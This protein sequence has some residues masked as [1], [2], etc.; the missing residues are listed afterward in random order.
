MVIQ[1]LDALPSTQRLMLPFRHK[2]AWK[3]APPCRKWDQ[4]ASG[5]LVLFFFLPLLHF[6]A[7]SHTQRFYKLQCHGPEGKTAENRMCIHPWRLTNAPGEIRAAAQAAPTCLLD[8]TRFP[9]NRNL[10]EFK[11]KESN[12]C[13]VNN[14]PILSQSLHVMGLRKKLCLL[15][16]GEIKLHWAEMNANKTKTLNKKKVNR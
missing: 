3:K 11:T 4:P 2:C 16:C 12:Y 13:Q 9:V 6:V 8:V 15:C 5:R 7:F 10:Q 14:V 1:Y